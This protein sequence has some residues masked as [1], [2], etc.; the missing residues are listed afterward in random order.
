MDACGWRFGDGDL[1]YPGD[2]QLHADLTP[3]DITTRTE[4][5]RTAQSAGWVF[6]TDRWGAPRLRDWPHEPTGAPLEVVDCVD[7]AIPDAL[8][9]HVIAFGADQSHLLNVA[10]VSKTADPQ[11][12]TCVLEDE[13]SISRFGRKSKALGFPLSGLSFADPATGAAFAVRV[14]NRWA[15]IVR[16]VS[17]FDAD[18]NVAARWL[19]VLVDLDTGRAVTV[20]RTEIHPFTL[21]AVVVGFSHL[22][23]PAAGSSHP[24]RPRGRSPGPTDR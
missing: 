16:Q 21:D 13:L 4:I 17:A 5:D 10:V 3:A 7:V 22:I 14:V 8:L 6:D 11:A 2:A 15:A 1:E 19:E 23:T 18:T 12:I 20:T 9:S 24:G